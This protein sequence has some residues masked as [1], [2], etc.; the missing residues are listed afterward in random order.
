MMR[1]KKVGDHPV[2]RRAIRSEGM[3]VA[4]KPYEIRIRGRVSNRTLA[5]MQGLQ[6]TVRPAQT[7]L[8]GYVPD[9]A[10]LYGIL[11]RIHS[12]GLELVELRQLSTADAANLSTQ[13]HTSRP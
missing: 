12:L 3:D 13:P 7:I 2:T 10:A 1:D 5:E 9:Q 11:Q 4:P 6:Q 8:T